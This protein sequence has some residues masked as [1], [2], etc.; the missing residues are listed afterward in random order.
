MSAEPAPRAASGT[1]LPSP[2]SRILATAVRLFYRNGINATGIGELVDV[3]GVSKRTLYQLFESKDELVVAYLRTMSTGVRTNE[4]CLTETGLTPRER[5]LALF[6]RPRVGDQFRGCPLHNASVELTDPQHP[7][8]PVITEHKRALLDRL[9]AT[10]KEAGATDPDVL[11]RQIFALFEGA[12]ALTTSLGDL[13]SFEFARPAAV[14][15]MDNA[16]PAHTIS[17]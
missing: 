8:R 5:L 10:A 15:L 6:D 9:V 3:A 13:E 2:R 14:L 11:G 4:D 17:A 12:M 1:R 7:G 16:I